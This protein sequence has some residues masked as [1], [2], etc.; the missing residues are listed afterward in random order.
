MSSKYI[1]QVGDLLQLHTGEIRQVILDSE[2]LNKEL[3]EAS[4]FAHT[5]TYFLVCKPEEFDACVKLSWRQKYFKH[6]RP[7]TLYIRGIV[8]K[9]V[10]RI[11]TGNKNKKHL[12]RRD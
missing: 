4:L 10:A 9:D 6:S 8:T 7:E 2:T 12:L 3:L 11:L 1:P 5:V